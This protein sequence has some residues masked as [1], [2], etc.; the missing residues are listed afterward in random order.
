M[1]TQAQ[2]RT[3]LISSP[4]QYL[5]G[6][7]V[8]IG[9]FIS[10]ILGLHNSGCSLMYLEYRLGCFTD[11]RGHMYPTTSDIS[12]YKAYGVGK[13]YYGKFFKMERNA[14]IEFKTILEWKHLQI[15]HPKEGEDL[16]IGTGISE[17]MKYP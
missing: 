10:L 6:E 2:A 16:F 17:K 3:L 14:G 4:P 11:H 8:P 13:S 12:I 7:V 9:Q 5:R 15:Y 1:D